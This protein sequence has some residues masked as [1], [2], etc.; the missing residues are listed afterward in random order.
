MDFM[1]QTLRIRRKLRCAVRLGRLNDVDQMVRANRLLRARGFRRANVH[2]PIHQRRIHAD[3]LDR[4]LLRQSQCQRG[5]TGGGR[6]EDEEGG[7][8]I[9]SH[10]FYAI[11]VTT[12]HVPMLWDADKLH[13]IH[14]VG[15]SY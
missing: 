6:A 13:N 3:D 14:T 1:N 2:A 8:F 9:L 15:S 11:R 7:G 5:F 10:A 4:P 12:I